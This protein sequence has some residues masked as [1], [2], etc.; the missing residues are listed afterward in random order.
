MRLADL[1]LCEILTGQNQ[2]FGF[3]Q[4]IQNPSVNVSYLLVTVIVAFLILSF[5]LQDGLERITK[6]MMT[7]C[8]FDCWCWR[9]TA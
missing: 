9:S 7:R 2:S 3:T 6:Y 8:S 1:L 4:M 5:D